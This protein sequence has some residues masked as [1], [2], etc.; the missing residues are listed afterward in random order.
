MPLPDNDDFAAF[1]NCV[2]AITLSSDPGRHDLVEYL[3]SP[4]LHVTV[5]PDSRTR[6][7]ALVSS[8]MSISDLKEIPW[9]SNISSAHLSSDC[10]TD[11][12]AL[13]QLERIADL[14]IL[15]DGRNFDD[16]DI[17]DFNTAILNLRQLKRLRLYVDPAE[18][19]KSKVTFLWPN[20]HFNFEIL[21][22]GNARRRG[23]GAI[24]GA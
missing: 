3:E 2:S 17:G 11:I 14:T 1:F 19:E 13:Y 15:I 5:A 20:S 23:P 8:W 9:S 12:P 18:L 6:P 24:L 7:G 16:D 10:L 21:A 4:D 22:N